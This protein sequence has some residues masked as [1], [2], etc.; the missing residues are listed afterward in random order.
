MRRS[1]RI[2]HRFI[3]WKLDTGCCWWRS[4]IWIGFRSEGVKEL[5]WFWFISRK[6]T[7]MS[8]IKSSESLQKIQREALKEWLLSP[9]DSPT[10]CLEVSSILKSKVGPLGQL[11][12]K[13]SA[14]KTS[15]EI[16]HDDKPFSCHVCTLI[17][18]HHFALFVQRL[19]S[20]VTR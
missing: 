1:L 19:C 2:M 14:I 9:K 13:K 6:L 17:C 5:S 11:S 10:V 12:A 8:S 20:C 4:W 7:W 3:G 16:L 15:Y 18:G